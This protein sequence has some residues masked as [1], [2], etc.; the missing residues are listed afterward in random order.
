MDNI[1]FK[2]I[3]K[4]GKKGEKGNTGISYDLPTNAIIAYDGEDTPEGFNNTEKPTYGGTTIEITVSGNGVYKASDY[5]VDAFS[6][7]TVSIV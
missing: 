5:G 2:A 4:K 7:V 6:K 1:I 3:L